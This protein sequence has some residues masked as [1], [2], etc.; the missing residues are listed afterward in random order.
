MMLC[1]RIIFCAFTRRPLVWDR[2]GI[3]IARP[4]T[5]MCK[6]QADLPLSLAGVIAGLDDATHQPIVYPI[7]SPVDIWAAT[8]RARNSSWANARPREESFAP[9][10]EQTK[11]I[12]LLCLFPNPS[13]S[14]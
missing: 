13:S 14:L 8:S 2:A 5:F 3:S 1:A 12:R 10:R 11:G 9:I 7:G 4:Y 6:P